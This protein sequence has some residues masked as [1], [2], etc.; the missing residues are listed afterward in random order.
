MKSFFILLL[1]TAVATAESAPNITVVVTSAQCSPSRAGLIT[2]RYQARFGVEEIALCPLP[3]EEKTIAEHLKP[4]GY[5][6]GF[7]GKWHLDVNVLCA[8]WLNENVPPEQ[9]RKQ[10]RGYIV[11]T[12]HREKFSPHAQGFDDYFS[13]ELI[14]YH[15]NFGLDATLDE[16][17]LLP[18]LTDQN[19]LIAQESAKA[20]ALRGMLVAWEAKMVPAKPRGN[21]AK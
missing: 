6:S 18:F 3:L 2:G 11:P 10:G 12:G 7:V 9:L 4:T 17:D 13:G 8:D 5:R 21:K 1:F 20:D 14:R 16:C 15:A 19:N